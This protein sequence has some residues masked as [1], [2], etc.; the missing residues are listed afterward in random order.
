[1]KEAF[2]ALAALLA[3]V[4]YF[5][6]LRDTYKGR[7]EPHA[8]TWLVWALVSGITF[9]GQVIK[10][11]GVG[12]IPT[13]LSLTFSLVIFAY[14]LRFGLKHI[15]RIDAFFLVAALLGLIPWALTSD[16]TL[17]VIVAVGIDLIAFIPTI[18]KTWREPHTETSLLYGL[19]A[20]R[21]VFSLFSLETYNIAT[22]LHSS[23]MIVANA[24]MTIMVVFR[25]NDHGR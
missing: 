13:A 21:H 7:V 11:A 23:A 5:P 4:G 3:V 6:Y 18:R 9:A 24:L 10:G 1:M 22:A 16:P 15:R 20:A 14:S 8:Y 2:A 17:S 25:R 12:A 19:N